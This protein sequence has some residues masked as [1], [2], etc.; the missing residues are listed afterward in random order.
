MEILGILLTID[1]CKSFILLINSIIFSAKYNI[2]FKLLFGHFLLI[3]RLLL[4]SLIEKILFCKIH[5]LLNE[6]SLL[7]VLILLPL[8]LF[9]IL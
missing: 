6:L 8:K 7:L 1:F 2:S 9:V 4:S 5:V 3:I